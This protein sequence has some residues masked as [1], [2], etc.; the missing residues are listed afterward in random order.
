VFLQKNK[1]QLFGV[2]M[3]A[4]KSQKLKGLFVKLVGKLFFLSCLW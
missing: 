4:G 2:Q 3:P 1:Q